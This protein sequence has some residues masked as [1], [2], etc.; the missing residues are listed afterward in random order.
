MIASNGKIIMILNFNIILINTTTHCTIQKNVSKGQIVSKTYQFFS[1]SLTISLSSGN[2]SCEL[3]CFFLRW[4]QSMI[5]LILVVL[6]EC[7]SKHS[8]DTPLVVK[9]V[10]PVYYTV[11]HPWLIPLSDILFYLWQL[12]HW[13]RDKCPTFSRRH[14]QM[15]FLE[16]KCINFD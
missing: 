11:Y 4:D 8:E 6:T 5:K 2:F 9:Y 10:F 1:I 12:T 14:F 7:F 16:W 13:G 15:H 3:L